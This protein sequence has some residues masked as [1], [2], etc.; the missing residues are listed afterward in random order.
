MDPNTICVYNISKIPLDSL[1]QQ[2][3]ELYVTF[4]QYFNIYANFIIV[5][6]CFAILLIT[7][8]GE[9]H[10]N[11]KW[12]VF[13]YTLLY[14]VFFILNIIFDLL[15]YILHSTEFDLFMSFLHIYFLNPLHDLAL[16]SGLPLAF[17]RFFQ[18]YFPDHYEEFFYKK[19][20]LWCL[21][22]D[23]LIVGLNF[24]TPFVSRIVSF[25]FILSLIS[26]I[27]LNFFLMCSM[28]LMTIFILL[29]I[30]KNLK[31]LKENMGQ[32]STLKEIRRAALGNI[33][34]MKMQKMLVTDEIQAFH[35]AP[36]GKRC[37]QES[38]SG[39]EKL[40]ASTQKHRC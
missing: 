38:K 27:A 2:S 28:I 29:K 19:S 11:F 14:F 16:V 18:M 36:I 4:M 30:R 8:F 34:W 32:K 21:G 5:L 10:E 31:L 35:G 15:F 6:L 17:N 7:L 22:Y 20:L 25:S 33:Q 26:Q 40:G 12:F 23:I 9:I 3:C 13:H 24:A 37:R 39:P 1:Q